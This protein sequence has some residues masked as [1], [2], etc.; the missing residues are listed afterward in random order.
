MSFSSGES[1]TEEHPG[2]HRFSLRSQNFVQSEVVYKRP[3]EIYIDSEFSSILNISNAENSVTEN[4]DFQTTLF[5][6]IPTTT[7]IL[8]CYI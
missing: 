4:P 3:S 8:M 7:H 6:T 2:R 1:Q 5:P